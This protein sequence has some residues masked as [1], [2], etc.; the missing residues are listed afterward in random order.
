[1]TRDLKSVTA[2]RDEMDKEIAE[3]KRVEANLRESQGQLIQAEK[4][5]AIGTL[6]AGV[7]HE[8]NNPMMGIL[9]F[10]QYCLK[11]TGE[12]DRRYT[13]LQDA[14]REVY[15][16]K[17]IVKNLLTF[18]RAD[19]EGNEP[20]QQAS[21]ATIFERVFK[22]LNYRIIGQGVSVIQHISSDTPEVWMK[23]NRIQ[24]V[25]FNLIGN[26]LDSLDKARTTKEI[27]IDIRPQGGFVQVSITDSGSG[28]AAKDLENIFQPFFTTKPVGKGTGLGL[29]MCHS[30]IQT[31]GGQLT[32]ESEL[33]IGTTFRVLLPIEPQEET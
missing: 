4:M 33:E 15:R 13:V 20:Y 9:N 25:F 19:N 16:C 27:I 23:V 7:A 2:S 6:T 1:M 14:E 17:D 3:R 8:L 10:V 5:S 26:A 22:L 24:Q 28:I 32:C 31:H 21:C 18:S 29:S 30:I 12:D 11:H